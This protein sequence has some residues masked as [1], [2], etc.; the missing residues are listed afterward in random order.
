MGELRSGMSGGGAGNR[1]EVGEV[2]VVGGEGWWRA[3]VWGLENGDRETVGRRWEAGCTDEPNGLPSRC[4]CTRA[5]SSRWVGFSFPLS[6][7]G[8]LGT[9]SYLDPG[10]HISILYIYI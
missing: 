1:R 9:E 3:A 4:S 2:A 7:F 10:V 5:A 6:A 8:S